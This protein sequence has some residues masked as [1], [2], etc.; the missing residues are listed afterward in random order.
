MKP[1]RHT[2]RGPGR[3]G[4]LAAAA[5]LC[6]ASPSRGQSKDPAQPEPPAATTVSP[7]PWVAM[8][9]PPPPLI[10]GPAA[11]S[12]EGASLQP[13]AAQQLPPPRV[14]TSG[15]GGPII[16][17]EHAGQWKL[18]DLRAFSATLEFYGQVQDDKQTSSTQPEVSEHSTLLRGSTTLSFESYIGH[19]N[20]IDLQGN[21]SFAYEDQTF[22][23]ANQDEHST[24]P[25][26]FYNI[27][28]RILGESFVPVT[29][30]SRRE[31]LIQNR[32]FAPT[33]TTVTTEHGAIVEVKSEDL[34]TRLQ[35]FHRE[36]SSSDGL[37]LS[38]GASTQD[39]FTMWST[40]HI[41]EHQSLEFNYTFDHIAETAL[42]TFNNDFDRHDATLTHIARFGTTL[43]DNLRS[44]LHVYSES[45]QYAQDRI[46]WDEQLYLRHSQNLQSNYSLS[47]E[48]LKRG[49]QE[50][51]Q[52]LGSASVSHKLFDSLVSS[53]R[54]GGSYVDLPGEFQSTS[55]FVSGSL[56]YTKKVPLGRL[57]AGGA[58]GY[59]HQDN[60]DRGATV[61][62][63]DEPR[64]F[65][66]P[67]DIIIARRNVI[68][69]ITVTDQAHIPKIEG[70]DFTAMIFP[71]R[72]EIHRQ[73][74]GTIAN[75]QTVLITYQVGPEPG[76]SI[77]TTTQNYSVRYTFNEGLLSGLSLYSYLQIVSHSI[78]A[79]D[80]KLYTLD[81]VTD[82]RYG[83]EYR[84][85]ELSL[86]VER[87][88]HDSTI[89]PY[90]LTR[91]QVRYDRRFGRDATLSLSLSRDEIDY[92]LDGNRVTLDNIL[93]RWSQRLGSGF[94]LRAYL[95]YRDEHN[96]IS[97]NV[98]GFEQSVELHWH[99]RQTSIYGAFHNSI[100][101]GG[102]GDRLSQT[103]TFGVTRSF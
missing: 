22:S 79:V 97:G 9:A 56:D 14:I 83:A 75:G 64:T 39:T 52:V 88:N 98:R 11:K 95:Q 50:Q 82:W 49:D 15:E 1:G 21:F 42:S 34:P 68:G 65:T 7:F 87:Q 38:N 19:K 63:F 3:I 60:G 40:A 61:T 100:L 78:N 86:L 94:D 96:E 71:D 99:W 12:E 93:A 16:L 43:E 80:P 81:D 31:E 66:D 92:R 45:G 17:G 10:A 18:W 101:M 24:S 103:I 4:A 70:T 85:R 67:F 62:V 47:V 36:Q 44:T 5:C 58:I 90:Y 57:D 32:E 54:A 55:E 73:P 77:D 41:G 6:A 23:S 30:Y 35:Y 37:G 48:E 46:R 29:V 20:F 102:D 26:D 69:P 91:Y 2:A 76:N 53:A 13:S 28:A 33:L 74:L 89:S 72:V 84:I 25:T 8:P 27:S 51:R 59:S